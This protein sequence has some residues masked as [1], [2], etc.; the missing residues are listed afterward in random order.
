M[1]ESRKIWARKYVTTRLKEIHHLL[2]EVN[3]V[4]DASE[5][6]LRLKKRITVTTRS[7]NGTAR[8]LQNWAVTKQEK[9]A[10]EIKKRERR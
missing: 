4:A 2:K 9:A 5:M 10:K 7:I 3:S 6:P 1:G 8:S